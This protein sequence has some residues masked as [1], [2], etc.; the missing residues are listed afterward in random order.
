MRA[1]LEKHGNLYGQS[2]D[3]MFRDWY[4]AL[5]HLGADE[6]DAVSAR[7]PRAPY[8]GTRTLLGI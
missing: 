1:I 3:A 2:G 4:A 8:N 7:G 5:D 6:S